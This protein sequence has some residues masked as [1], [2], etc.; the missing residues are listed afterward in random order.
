MEF[1]SAY[2]FI[3]AVNYFTEHNMLIPF[4]IHFNAQSHL[5][6]ERRSKT[7]HQIEVNINRCL[8]ISLSHSLDE[9]TGEC[10]QAE[11]GGECSNASSHMKMQHDVSEEHFNSIFMI[12][13]L[14]SS[15]NIIIRWSEEEV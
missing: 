14:T 8:L 9:V 3:L 5:A 12:G 11:Y 1:P 2:L 4:L 10:R 13:Y 6:A 7:W 15:C